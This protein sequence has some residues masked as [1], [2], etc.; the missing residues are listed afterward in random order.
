MKTIYL[1]TKQNGIV[2]TVDQFTQGVDAPANYR[3]FKAYVRTIIDEYHLTGQNV[4]KSQ[5]C[6]KE[7]KNS[8]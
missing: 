6:T 4:Y 7:W 2:E 8:K 5:R 1:N 3:E